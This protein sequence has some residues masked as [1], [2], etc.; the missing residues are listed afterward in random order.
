MLPISLA[1]N[2]SR[3]LPGRAHST[4]WHSTGEALSTAT[5][6]G[7]L[8]PAVTAMILVPLPRR[9]GPTAKPLFW[10]WRKWHLQTLRPDST[11]L[12]REDAVPAQSKPVPVCRCGPTAESGDGRS[13]MVDTCREVHATTLRCPTPAVHHSVRL[14][15]RAMDGRAHRRD[16]PDAAPALSSPIVTVVGHFPA[17]PHR[18][19][20][21]LQST[22]RMPH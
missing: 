15:C 3:K 5:A 7:R 10:R 6:R 18:S 8:V 9:V 19:D 22:S 17:S 1:G 16:E 21:V 4:N 20:G 2:W 12:V 13:E 14:W 11:G